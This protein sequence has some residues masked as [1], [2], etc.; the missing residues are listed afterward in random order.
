MDREAFELLVLR[1]PLLRQT[2]H[3]SD[4]GDKILNLFAEGALRIRRTYIAELYFDTA[5][6]TTRARRVLR[7]ER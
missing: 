6:E 5:T 4:D 3:T 2:V 7:Y 1:R